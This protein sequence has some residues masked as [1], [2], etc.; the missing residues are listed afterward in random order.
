[1][2]NLYKI[3][4]KPLDI[5]VNESYNS[6]SKKYIKIELDFD[7]NIKYN[8]NLYHDFIKGIKL[9]QDK[10]TYF[11]IKSNYNIDIKFLR[12][13]Y[14]NNKY[15]ITFLTFCK[16]NKNFTEKRF[17]IYEILNNNHVIYPFL[18]LIN[19][20][21]LNNLNY[22]IRDIIIDKIK[23]SHRFIIRIIK[24]I[25]IIKIKKELTKIKGI[26]YSPVTINTPK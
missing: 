18:K 15:I 26:L 7:Y 19:T 11:E 23:G 5:Y 3:K 17:N 16:I 22:D 25:Y 24:N 6:L 20:Y 12:L 21:N 2:N 4:Y 10:F 1:M 9:F 13:Y 14:L 8:H